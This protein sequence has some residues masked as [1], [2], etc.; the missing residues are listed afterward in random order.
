MQVF[1][2]LRR[3]QLC[4]AAQ[5][6]LGLLGA[7]GTCQFCRVVFC[8]LSRDLRHTRG[9]ASAFTCTRRITNHNE[10]WHNVTVCVLEHGFTC[11]RS[12]PCIPLGSLGQNGCNHLV[13]DGQCI[14]R[15]LGLCWQSMVYPQGGRPESLWTVE[16]HAVLWWW[17][18]CWGVGTW[19]WTSIGWVV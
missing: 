19:R 2:V 13:T 9:Y 7:L 14:N 16:V 1:C 17:V 3:A 4:D 10:A 18:V 15:I 5:C 6:W 11:S 12:L 8:C